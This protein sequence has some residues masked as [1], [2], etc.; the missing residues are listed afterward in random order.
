MCSFAKDNP[1]K[2]IIIGL[3]MNSDVKKEQYKKWDMDS[4]KDQL[5]MKNLI[6]L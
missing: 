2:I 3:S 4:W 5:K 1:D 6:L